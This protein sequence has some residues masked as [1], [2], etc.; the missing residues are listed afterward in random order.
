RVQDTPDSVDVVGVPD[1]VG[2]DRRRPGRAL[3]RLGHGEVVAFQAAVVTGVDGVQP[4]VEPPR[5]PWLEPLPLELSL[6]QLPEASGVVVFG[7]ADDPDGQRQV[8]YGWPL[9]SGSLAFF[10]GV[11][12]QRSSPLVA[13]ASAVV[14]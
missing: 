13:V 8:P 5:R 3:V 7:V 14:R 10:A 9:G 6:E 1:A 2:L 12:G 4:A 11:H